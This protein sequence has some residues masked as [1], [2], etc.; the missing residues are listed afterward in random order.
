MD[1]Y[2]VSFPISNLPMMDMVSQDTGQ[3]RNQTH[4]PQCVCTGVPPP[5]H[6]R[7]RRSHSDENLSLNRQLYKDTQD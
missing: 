4:N 5:S 2:W 3:V 7:N 1:L 6:F